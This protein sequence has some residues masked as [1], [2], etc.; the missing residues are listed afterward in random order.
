[1]GI[2]LSEESMTNLNRPAIA[3]GQLTVADVA[4]ARKHSTGTVHLV[5]AGCGQGKWPE[6]R[7]N[8]P[9]TYWPDTQ[10]F[11]DATRAVESSK[12]A[13]PMDAV[14]SMWRHRSIAAGVRGGIGLVVAIAV[15]SYI[16]R[17]IWPQAGA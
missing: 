14:E 15:A 17:A 3:P 4:A 7:V 5:P 6:R 9:D 12:Q 16:A 8:W 11:D 1:M 10:A 13:K 2:V